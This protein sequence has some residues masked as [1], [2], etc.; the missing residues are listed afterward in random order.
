MKSISSMLAGAA[1]FGFLKVVGADWILAVTCGITAAITVA[2]ALEVQRKVDHTKRD[3]S[4]MA[5]V[6]F[7]VFL[8]ST[9]TLSV[10]NGGWNRSGVQWLILNAAWAGYFLGQLSLSEQ[11]PKK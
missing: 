2:G 1:V 4:F 5:V 8:G 9:G 7:I 6:M 10:M 11:Q 3:S